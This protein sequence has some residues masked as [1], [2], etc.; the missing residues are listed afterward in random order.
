L[1]GASP[2]RADYKCKGPLLG[3]RKPALRWV[4]RNDS[5]PSWCE[6]QETSKALRVEHAYQTIQNTQRDR[7]M[8]KTRLVL[9]GLGAVGSRIA[10]FLLQKEGTEIVGAID[11]AK[12]KV[13]KDL[14][15]VLGVG[16]RLGIIV[17]GDPDDVFSRIKADAVVHATTSFL[18]Q[19]YP[20]IAKAVKHGL[21]VVS[22]CEELSYPYTAAP[23]LAKKL[24]RLAEEHGAT[25]LGTGINP[26]FLMDTLAI[27]LTGVCQ[28]IERIGIKRVMNA[29]TRRVPFQKKIGAGLTAKEFQDKMKSKAITGHVGLRESISMIAS[30]LAWKLDEIKVDTVEPVIA[31]KYVESEAI[32]VEPGQAAGLKQS[33]R[34]IR[35]K[36]EAISL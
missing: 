18:Q 27:T 16:K 28:R 6:S 11:I 4:L 32:R 30:A 15:D 25:V 22:T 34:G 8:E 29:A 36:G 7:G 2:R 35:E 13:G 31:K 17:S 23:K 3:L 10:K 24:H 14:G 26:G 12:D 1:R 19:T 5:P 33:A 21:N 9:Y 20:Q